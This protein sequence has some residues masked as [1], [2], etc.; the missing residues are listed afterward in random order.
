MKQ[1][2]ALKVA[3]KTNKLFPN[4]VEGIGVLE[5]GYE[6]LVSW[7]EPKYL[8]KAVELNPNY[9]EA[10]I[11]RALINIAKEDKVRALSDLET[12]HHLKPHLK[13]IWV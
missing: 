3:E 9:A 2:E 5:F 6:Q 4:D 1:D 8:N 12:A 10:I 13:Q 7:R 11:N